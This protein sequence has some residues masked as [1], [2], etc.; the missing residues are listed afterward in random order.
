MDLRDRAGCTAASLIAWLDDA[1]ARE[2]FEMV[3]DRKTENARKVLEL[4]HIHLPD[5]FDLDLEAWR[6]PFLRELDVR[7]SSE[8]TSDDDSTSTI[9]D[10]ARFATDMRRIDSLYALLERI[11]DRDD[12]VDIGAAFGWED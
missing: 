5:D 11:D 9:P 7:L 10:Y 1:Q 6:A 3:R 2:L 8:D 12:D 4:V